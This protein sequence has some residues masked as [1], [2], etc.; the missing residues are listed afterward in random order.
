MWNVLGNKK[1]R[2]LLSS[3]NGIFF[4]KGIFD[5]G[6]VDSNFFQVTN[7]LQVRIILY[8]PIYINYQNI[9]PKNLSG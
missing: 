3:I 8:F 9:I 4:L 1:G 6:L 5:S 2:I 7:L